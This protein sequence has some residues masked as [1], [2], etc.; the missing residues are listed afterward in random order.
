MCEW[1]GLER[2]VRDKDVHEGEGEREGGLGE[3]NGLFYLRGM[4]QAEGTGGKQMRKLPE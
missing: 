4:N 3:N 1:G 2:W